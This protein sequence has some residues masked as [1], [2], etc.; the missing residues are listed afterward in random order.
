MPKFRFF[1]LNLV[2]VFVHARVTLYVSKL[3]TL[4]E[5]FYFRETC[6]SLHRIV[7]VYLLLSTGNTQ[8]FNYSARLLKTVLQSKFGIRCVCHLARLR[9][10]EVK[11]LT[12]TRKPTLTIVIKVLEEYSNSLSKRPVHHQIVIFQSD[13]PM[14]SIILNGEGYAPKIFDLDLLV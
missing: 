8:C 11:K 5:H 10:W 12:L 9:P 13:S 3:T 14:L 6:C 4:F 2:G 1:I 7:T